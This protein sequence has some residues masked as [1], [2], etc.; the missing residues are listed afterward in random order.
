MTSEEPVT[1][2]RS[3]LI[4]DGEN[5]KLQ[6]SVLVQQTSEETSVEVDVPSTTENYDLWSMDDIEGEVMEFLDE[7]VVG[8]ASLSMEKI[9]NN[10]L[11]GYVAACG[12]SVIDEVLASAIARSGDS[13]VDLNDDSVNNPRALLGRSDLSVENLDTPRK[14]ALDESYQRRQVPIR[15]PKPNDYDNEGLHRAVK[16]AT[17]SY[18]HPASITSSR[19]TVKSKVRKKQNVTTTSHGESTDPQPGVPY[20]TEV[21]HKGKLNIAS[22]R[23]LNYPASSADNIVVAGLQLK[24]DTDSIRQEK[25]EESTGSRRSPPPLS[26]S[27]SSATSHRRRPQPPLSAQPTKT[28]SFGE[29]EEEVKVEFAILKAPPKRISMSAPSALPYIDRSTPRPRFPF[30]AF[31]VITDDQ[32]SDGDPLDQH[33]YAMPLSPG[34]K[35]RTGEESNDGPELPSFASK[36]RRSTFVRMDTI[37]LPTQASNSSTPRARTSSPTDQDAVQKLRKGTFLTETDA[38]EFSAADRIKSQV[39]P[40]RNHHHDSNDWTKADDVLSSELTT[41]C[42]CAS[43]SS[44]EA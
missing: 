6:D 27:P 43:S 7:I 9:V 20:S 22:P 3:T 10:R 36:M 18:A 4:N 38:W 12:L 17:R 25:T 44:L 32:A 2:R 24:I 31:S 26:K 13:G 35:V 37:T 40:G 29:R 16:A 34:V 5:D 30:P 1:Q 8:S 11:F 15:A 33:F 14:C 21:P 23:K 41:S 42:S 19:R 28:L 39:I